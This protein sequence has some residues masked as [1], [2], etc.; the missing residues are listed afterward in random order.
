ME[1]LGSKARGPHQG[2][3]GCMGNGWSQRAKGF[4]SPPRHPPS[5]CCSLCSRV[6]CCSAGLLLRAGKLSLYSQGST[7]QQLPS[8]PKEEGS[9]LPLT[10]G[11]RTSL[12]LLILKLGCE[13]QTR[14][15]IGRSLQTV[16]HY[17][18]PSLSTM[19]LWSKAFGEITARVLS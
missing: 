10:R 13:N 6:S 8:T 17:K 16:K 5:H 18:M 12:S 15:C 1:V 19:P 11:P 14:G 7:C 9:I 4:T 2:V 3:G